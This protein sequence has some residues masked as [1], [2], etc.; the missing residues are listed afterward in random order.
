M[1]AAAHE[2]SFASDGHTLVGSLLLPGDARRPAAAVLLLPGSGPVDRDSDHPRARLGV[3]RLLAEA[4]ADAGIASF[5]YD[6]RGVG[7][8][9]GEFLRVGFDDNAADARAALATLSAQPEIDAQRI[10]V[11]G[12]SEGAFH[13]VPLGLDPVAGLVLLAGAAGPAEDVVRYQARAVIEVLPAPVRALLR[14]L[15][16][17]VGAQHRKKLDALRATTT[18]VTGWGP[19]RTNARWWREF[20]AAD[21]RPQLAALDV[22]VLAITG[23]HDVQVDPAD[24][25]AIAT[26][27]A[28]G[29]SYRAP[30]VTHILR[31]TPRAV[32]PW[33]YR[34]QLAAPLAADVVD[35]VVAFVRRVG[36]EHA[37]GVERTGQARCSSR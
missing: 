13:A 36:A 15:P 35:R 4:L 30:R 29:E 10:V 2:L 27:V 12:H 9:T 32:G 21:P 22:P 6:K 25:E 17:D 11:L 33:A 16:V 3:T 28:R 26:L 34:R 1:T 7:A 24:A 8:S 14:L 20:L 5:R 37:D 18:D 19:T 23:D 31:R